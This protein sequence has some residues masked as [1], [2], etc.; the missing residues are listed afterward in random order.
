MENLID[1]IK[2]NTFVVVDL[3]TT[4]LN[5]SLEY[6]EVDYIIE[7]GAVKIEKGKITQKFRA[8]RP[9][10]NLHFTTNTVG[11]HDLAGF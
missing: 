3:E 1:T 4:G 10:Q 2:R 7:I 6:G 11:S 8:V 5:N 9:G